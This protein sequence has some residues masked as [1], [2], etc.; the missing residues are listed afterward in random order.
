MVATVPADAYVAD[1]ALV[2]E[3]AVVRPGLGSELADWAEMGAAVLGLGDG[4]T[5]HLDP[6][7]VS[8]GSVGS[9]W[10]TWG[11]IEV[12]RA[13]PVAHLEVELTTWPGQT[14]ELVLRPAT[15]RVSRWGRR[16]QERY[17]TLVHRAADRL[18]QALVL[19]PWPT[20]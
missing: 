14:G 18:A 1:V 6:P 8:S 5:L 7:E 2:V 11:R 4:A 19:G 16:R 3:R 10:R 12:G 17:F 9:S 13:R 15:G 20:G